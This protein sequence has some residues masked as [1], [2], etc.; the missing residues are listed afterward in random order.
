MAKK[1]YEV[2]GLATIEVLKRVKANDEDEAIELAEQYFNGLTEFCGNGGTDKLVGVYEDSESVQTCVDCIEWQ[3]AYETDDDRY[4]ENTNEI[5]FTC[6]LCGEEFYYTSEDDDYESD[7]LEHL[8]TEH[9]NEAEYE[10]YYDW[11][12]ITEYFERED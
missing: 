12:M 5:T 11:Q 2:R 7:L 3:D 8:E 6:K 10:E 9:E 4:D 1:I